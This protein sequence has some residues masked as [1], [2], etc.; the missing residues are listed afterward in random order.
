MTKDYD[1]TI[2]LNRKAKHDYIIEESFE[3]GLILLG[4][5][6][7]SARNRTIQLQEGHVTI[8]SGEAYLVNAHFSVP[9]TTCTHIKADPKRRR[10]L[11]LHQRELNKL[12]GLVQQKGFT[13]IPCSLYWKNNRVKMNLALG[14]GKKLHDKRASIKD[15]DWKR[16]QDRELKKNQGNS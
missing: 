5:E 10:K 2:T 3:A 12:I 6:V 9:S 15:R 7:K 11:L 13:L 14:R 8:K 16:A 1:K 4:W